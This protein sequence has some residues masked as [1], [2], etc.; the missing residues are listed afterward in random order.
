M[1]VSEF[2]FEL[3]EERIALRPV[4]PRH[5][6]KQLIVNG[7]SLADKTVFDLPDLLHPNDLIVLNDTKVI[8]SYFFVRRGDMITECNLHKRVSALQWL[9][10]I[11][12]SKRLKEGERLEFCE[13]KL[14][15]TIVEKRDEGEV[16][17]NFDSRVGELDSTLAEIGLMP[18]PPY[19]LSKR[20]VD[21]RD[22]DDYQTMF[23]EKEGA[24]A[25]P[26][27]SLHFTDELMARLKNKG[28]QT[29]TLTLHVGAGT[30]LPMKAEDTKDHKMHSEW[31][32]V[33]PEAAN[34]I[35]K[36][37][38]HQGRIIAVGT[39]VLRLLETA[40]DKNGVTHPFSGDTDIFITPGFQFNCADIL[41]TNFHLPK[42]TLFMLVSAF[43]GLDNMKSAYRHAIENK[44]RFYSYGDSSLL[45]RNKS[46]I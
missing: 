5:S 29:T 31:G 13:G 1:H 7:Q 21:D 25:A 19:I 16:L 44:Y 14:Y 42:S 35:N 36:T 18:L 6:A 40:T 3:P 43:A 8:P 4:S 32:E 37:H 26:T 38:A 24:V 15:A 39:T 20:G 45:F 12:K 2:D 27:A 28:I 30:F 46:V 10:F 11:K 17:L 9:A 34:L 41:M 22:K 33:S 23:A